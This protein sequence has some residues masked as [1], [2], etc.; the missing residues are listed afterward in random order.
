MN[1]EISWAQT[2]VQTHKVPF[3]SILSNLHKNQNMHALNH[4]RSEIDVSSVDWHGSGQK[5]KDLEHVRLQV[6]EAEMLCVGEGM[7][8]WM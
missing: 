5:V 2:Q 6:F 7:K 4:Q 1:N 8:V 3:C